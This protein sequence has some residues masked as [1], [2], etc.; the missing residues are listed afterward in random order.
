MENNER[1]QLST[2]SF[3]AEELEHIFTKLPFEI[4]FVGPDDTV[5]FFSDKP[6]EEKLFMRSKPSLG[7]DLHV[8]H[9]KKYIPLM[10]QV[11]ADFKSGA[12][13]H[14]RF[15]RQDHQGKFISIDYYALRDAEGSY[16]GALETVQ[17]ISDLKKLEGDRNEVL[18]L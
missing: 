1:I 5:R 3:S 17:D 13:S 15:W 12:Q 10:E 6:A 4:S 9:P 14:A 11:I 7:K 2:G 16:M 8:C 18:Y